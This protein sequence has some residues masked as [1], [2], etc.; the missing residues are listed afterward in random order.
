MELTS[1]FEL[2][3]PKFR[4]LVGDKFGQ[5][6]VTPFQAEPQSGATLSHPVQPLH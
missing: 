1:N 3:E 4:E 5:F 6:M 2:M